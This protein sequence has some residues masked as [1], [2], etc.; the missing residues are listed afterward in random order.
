MTTS[1]PQDRLETEAYCRGLKNRQYDGPV[2]LVQLRYH[3]PE[4]YLKV[5]LAMIQDYTLGFDSLV[6]QLKA[7]S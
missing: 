5:I 2:F 3:R 7:A 1:G 4:A 6:G